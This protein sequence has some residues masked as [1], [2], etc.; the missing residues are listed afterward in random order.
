[1]NATYITRV[2]SVVSL[3]QLDEDIKQSSAAMSQETAMTPVS[4]VEGLKLPLYAYTTKF[5]GGGNNFKRV[6]SVASISCVPDVDNGNGSESSIGVVDCYNSEEDVNSLHSSPS[7]QQLVP[8]VGPLPQD[9]VMDT[10]LMALWED[11]AEQGLFRYDVTSTSTKVLPGNFG[12]VAQLNEGRATQ[13]R[14]TEFRVDQVVQPFDNSKFNF[15][16]AYMREVLFMFESTSTDSKLIESSSAHDSPSVVLINVSP[17]EFGHVLLVPRVNDCIQQLVDP[18]TAHMALR[19]AMEAANPFFRVGYN[20]LGAYATINHLHFQAYY[21]AAPFPCERATTRPLDGSMKRKRG[22]VRISRTVN[23][24]VNGFVLEV[25]DSM[26]EMAQVLGQACLNMQAANIPHNILIC[27]SGSRV[28]LWP[29][30]YAERQAAGTVPED[31]LE[32]GVNPACFE[33][34]GHMVLKRKEDYETM[35]QEHAWKMLEQVSLPEDRF[36]QVAQL[37]FGKKM[38]DC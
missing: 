36:L 28:F 5:S 11:C 23:Y 30:C 14:P 13:K 20:S 12:F 29:Q 38:V 1:M 17:I 9:S 26:L 8:E 33:I 22:G 37:C 24:P 6:P 32:T 2:E 15:S 31:V 34:A 25:K 19:F 35:T 21:L 16:K 7:E 4:K 3:Q 10:V 27:D 18:D